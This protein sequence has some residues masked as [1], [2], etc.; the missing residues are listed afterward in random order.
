MPQNPIQII[1]LVLPVIV[2]TFAALF[3]EKIN[4]LRQ[5]VILGNAIEGAAFTDLLYK[6]HTHKPADM[7]GQGGGRYIECPLDLSYGG[8]FMSCLHEKT[9]DCQACVIA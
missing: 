6:A 9:K 8:T 1:Y 7:V 4:Q 2:H 3:F 5:N